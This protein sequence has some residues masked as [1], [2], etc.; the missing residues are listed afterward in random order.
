MIHVSADL[1]TGL[2]LLCTCFK[3]MHV[4]QKFILYVLRCILTE[5]NEYSVFSSVLKMSP[6]QTKTFQ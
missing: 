5:H 2:L 3:C 6:K 4:G 1:D